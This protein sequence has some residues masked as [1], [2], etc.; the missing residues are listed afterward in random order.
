MHSTRTVLAAACCVVAVLS[1]ACSDGSPDAVLDVDRVGPPDGPVP[2]RQASLAEAEWPQAAAWIRREAAAGRPVV[3]NFFASWCG[4]CKREAPLLEQARADNPAVAFLGIAYQDFIGDARNFLEQTG[5]SV[6]TLLDPD[7]SI[8]AQVGVRGMPTT[9]FFDA[10]GRLV[11]TKTG[12][13]SEQE[14]QRGLN[15]LTASQPRPTS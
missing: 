4:P 11:S 3:V 12:E 10:D 9:L 8:G 5:L 14:L 7:G 2:P 1:A 15:E 13:L 6:P